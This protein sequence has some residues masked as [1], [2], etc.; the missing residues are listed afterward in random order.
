MSKDMDKVLSFADGMD[1]EDVVEMDKELK[2]FKDKWCKKLDAD[3]PNYLTMVIWVAEIIH[4]STEQ[5]IRGDFI[6][7]NYFVTD[8]FLDY[9]R[10]L[11]GELPNYATLSLSKATI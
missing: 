11:I 2:Q 8:A 10:P 3:F 4:R 7:D 5:I 9:L 6:S 1:K